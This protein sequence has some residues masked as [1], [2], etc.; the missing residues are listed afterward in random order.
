MNRF[1]FRPILI[2]TISL[3]LGILSGIVSGYYGYGY[4]IILS[5]I[6]IVIFSVF[7]IIRRKLKWRAV[8]VY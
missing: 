2:I 1:N 8:I 6:Y 5:A 4:L 3:V 7:Y